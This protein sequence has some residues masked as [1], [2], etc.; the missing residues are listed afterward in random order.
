MDRVKEAYKL[1]LKA[2]IIVGAIAV[3]IFELCPQ[4][5]I[6]IFG[7]GNDLYQ[8]FAIKTFRI[9]LSLTVITCLVKMTAVFFQSI[10]KSVHAVVASLI[11]DIVC[12]TPLA[13]FLPKLLEKRELGSGINGILFA[14]PIS[15]LVAVIVIIVLT[16]SFLKELKKSEAPVNLEEG[17]IRPS[18]P[19][20]IITIAREH[21]TAGKTI[22]SMVAQQLGIPFY[23]K[24]MTALAA[25][26]S[27]LDKNFILG[28]NEDGPNLLYDLYLST[29]VV[30]RAVIAQEQ[31]IRSIADNGSCVIVGR[32]ADY[33]LRDYDNVIRVFIHGPKDYRVANLMEMYGDSHEDAVRHIRHSDA[34]RSSY[35]R[36]ISGQHWGDPHNYHICLDASMGKE[37][38]AE[39]I[40][41]IVQKSQI[42]I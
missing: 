15:D 29:N 41:K 12:F 9:Y 24:E 7:S 14:A 23:Y 25:Q 27:G 16:T 26:E 10:G 28:L 32:A 21:G 4:L 13:I 30:Q 20:P 42:I 6:G 39:Q 19:G 34:A 18:V 37:F 3:L 8:E 5:V 2:S 36:N 40:C 31:V 35:Y 17:V 22:G 38:C 33:V 11:R 1:V